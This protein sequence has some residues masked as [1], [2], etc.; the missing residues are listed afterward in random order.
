MCVQ[1]LDV[2]DVGPGVRA[3]EQVEAVLACKR[4]EGGDFSRTDIERPARSL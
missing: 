4:S 1:V 2:D 3:A